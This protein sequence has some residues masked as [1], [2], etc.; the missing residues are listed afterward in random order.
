VALTV[1]LELTAALLC[2]LLLASA[3]KVAGTYVSPEEEADFMRRCAA[4]AAA[5]DPA[6][7]AGGG[8]ASPPAPRRTFEQH[9]R[10]RCE[11]QWRLAFYLFV[12]GFPTFFGMM[13]VGAFLK[14]DNDAFGAPSIPAA[15]L[16]AAIVGAMLAA[17]AWNG[18]SW[19]RALLQRRRPGDAGLNPAKWHSG[20]PLSALNGGGG[21]DGDGRGGGG[22]GGDGAL[23]LPFSW[24]RIPL[25]AGAVGL[26]ASAWLA[27]PLW[28]GGGGGDGRDNGGRVGGGAG[29]GAAA[30]GTVARP[31]AGQPREAAG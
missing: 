29:A 30:E 2:T 21:S 28:A 9:W 16:T 7:A 26:P 25:P 23:G 15:A 10:Q 24:H 13:A 17:A 19:Q 20:L 22:G 18:G 4:F 6:A 1:G 11:A 14:F 8:G 31:D 12:A 3:V 5:Y 27:A